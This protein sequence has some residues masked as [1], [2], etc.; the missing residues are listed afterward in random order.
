VNPATSIGETQTNTSGTAIQNAA[1]Q[2]IVS[3]N[4]LQ[5][6]PEPYKKLSQRS[7]RFRRYPRSFGQALQGRV[8]AKREHNHQCHN[9]DC[10]QHQ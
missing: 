3:G 8:M 5:Q 1:R 2:N 9:S 7:G 6:H 4:L 10:G